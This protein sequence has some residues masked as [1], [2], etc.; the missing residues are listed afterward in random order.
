MWRHATRR[1][2]K[3]WSGR[4]QQKRGSSQLQ[5]GQEQQQQPQ[6]QPQLGKEQ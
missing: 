1:P 3:T 5:Q 4:L 6:Q 2:P